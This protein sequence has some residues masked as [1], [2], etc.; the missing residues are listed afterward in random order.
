MENDV[1]KEGPPL[2]KTDGAATVLNLAKTTLEKDRLTGELGIPFIRMGRSVR[3][4][5]KDLEA[6]KAARKHNRVQEAA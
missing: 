2:L 6:Y 4:D 5:P 1:S 3:Y